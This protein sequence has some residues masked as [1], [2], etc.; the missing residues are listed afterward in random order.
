MDP[1]K[2]VLLF[3]SFTSSSASY[4]AVN[5]I[6]S[7]SKK[8]ANVYC[9]RKL[10]FAR[11]DSASNVQVSSKF[12]AVFYCQLLYHNL[13]VP[14][15]D[16]HVS[17]IPLFNS[18]LVGCKSLDN[19][20]S[21]RLRHAP[22]EQV[23]VHVQS[24]KSCLR[25]FLPFKYELRR[26]N[27]L[28]HH[29]LTDITVGKEPPKPSYLKFKY[30]KDELFLS[31]NL[32]PLCRED[33]TGAEYFLSLEA[34]S[35]H[36][37][38]STELKCNVFNKNEKYE[39]LCKF[40]R[41]C[42]GESKCH[43]KILAFIY[44]TNR[45]GVNVN[46]TS[47]KFHSLLAFADA[48]SLSLQVIKPSTNS[49][50]VSFRKPV[51]CLSTLSHLHYKV[52]YSE[53]SNNAETVMK[54]YEECMGSLVCNV[55]IPGL[56]SNTTYQVCIQYHAYFDY[57]STY[58][59]PLCI[60]T[61]TGLLPCSSSNFYNLTRMKLNLTH[62][63][64]FIRVQPLAAECWNSLSYY[65]K[66]QLSSTVDMRKK[67]ILQSNHSTIL[68]PLLRSSSYYVIVSACNLYGCRLGA[69]SDRIDNY[70]RQNNREIENSQVVVETAL[71]CVFSVLF[72]SFSTLLYFVLRRTKKLPRLRRIQREDIRLVT[73]PVERSSFSD[74]QIPQNSTLV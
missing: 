39:V 36:C 50:T 73:L 28:L 21:L 12:D 32:E 35:E 53:I 51:D 25:A 49:I 26:A 10:S 62:Y 8:P 24:H 38:N 23:E 68:T 2:V 45:Y 59:P 17:M 41:M 70:L 42:P 6:I 44:G 65:Y 63:S 64:A 43:V 55:T 1:V 15:T 61:S 14:T 5:L 27:T 20:L 48:K 66:V 18:S 54:I 9:P 72:I 16:Y 46:V 57:A 60:T 58:T 30:I 52:R 34:S 29:G 13:T 37:R 71:M 56:Y 19:C 4:P 67:I 69:R 74:T 40:L 11:S 33:L 31:S 3:L 7:T 47:P 22:T